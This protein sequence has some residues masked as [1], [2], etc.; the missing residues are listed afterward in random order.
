[1][2]PALR[3]LLALARPYRGR[4][5]LALLLAIASSAVWLAV[6]LG[7]RALLDSVF[8]EGNG[9]RLDAIAA[10]LL[11]LFLVS[12][13]LGFGGGYLIEW[14][15]ERVVADLR[16]RLYGHLVR[17]DLAF[18]ARE[19]TGDVTSRLTSDVG[20]VRSAV[21]SSLVEL[22]TQ[23]L[24]L[25]G[26]VALMVTLNARLSV[27]VFAVVPFVALLARWVGVRVRALSRGVQDALAGATAHAEEAITG[28]R[29]VQAFGREGHEEA[30][31]GAA[32]EHVFE[33]ARRSA[34]L[35]N[36]FW[37]V[38]G[39]LFLASLVGIFWF[40][41]REVLA[42]RLTAGD[43]VAFIF[44]AF[45]IARSVGGLARL[46]TSFASAAG[47]SSRLFELLDTR[48]A[49]VEL[50]GAHA[51]PAPARGAVAFEDVTFGYAA[52]PGM[53]GKVDRNESDADAAAA[54]R[55]VL[56]GVTLRAEPGE[57]VAIVGPSGAG[58]TTLLALLP[59]FYD[60]TGGRVTL[61]GHDVRDLTLGSLRGALASVPQDVHLFATTVRENIRYGR[62]GATDAEVEDA[63]RRAHADG[64]IRALP[65]GYEAEVGERGVRLSGGERQ[66]ISIARALLRDAP[67][68]LLDEATSA[69]DAAS[70]RAVQ[71]AL[72][73][74]VEGRTTFVV[75]HRLATVVR[76]DRIVVLDHGRVVESGTHAELVAKGGLYAELA[77]MQFT[78]DGG[79]MGAV[80]VPNGG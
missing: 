44:Y 30:R 43:L 48:S 80:A 37:T 6:P 29:S 53:D 41:G 51:L 18:F 39:T 25:A 79:G 56:R 52:A 4:L 36:A 22:V 59:R 46:Y 68:L 38:V 2:L 66:R 62:D 57:T 47:A 76:A 16:R 54:P 17:L 65:G 55:A 11:G 78:G 12:A 14:T 20:A 7:L 58:K 73:V 45:N 35:T 34:L 74:L 42:G 72:D 60:V 28:I 75:A 19:R 67:V 10:G 40:G 50:P 32:S 26:S 13:L 1:M 69:L 63:A 8:E 31:Y 64:F 70:E 49:I 15:G 24:S 5:L 77:A 9:A 21:T 33:V 27:A 3:R 61:D 23:S 71:Q